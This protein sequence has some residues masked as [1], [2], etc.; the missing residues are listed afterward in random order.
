[1]ARALLA[2]SSAAAALWNYAMFFHGEDSVA[3]NLSPFIDAAPARGAE[4]LPRHPAGRRG[5]P[6]RLLRAL[7]ARGRRRRAATLRSSPG[8]R[9][10]RS[11]RGAFA[12]S[13]GASTGW[14]SEL[15]RDRSRPKL[16]QADHALPHRRRGDAGPARPALHRGLPRGPRRAAR[17]PRRACATSRS[18][19]SATSASGSSCSPTWC[20]EDPECK[21]AVAELL[22]EVVPLLARACSCPPGWDR[23]LHRRSSASRSRTSSSTARVSF[24][25]KLRAAGLPVEELPGLAYPLRPPA[26]RARRARRCACSRPAWSARR[27]AR[28][29][30]TPRRSPMLFDSVRRAVDPRARAARGRPRSSGTSPTPSP[31]TCGVDNGSTQR[32]AGP[33]WR[34]PTSRCAAASRTGSTWPPAARTRAGR[35]PPGGC[36]P[37][38]A[39][40]RS[41]RRATSSRAD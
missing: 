35:W 28:P 23:A 41:G 21:D 7:H 31:G 30:A 34:R 1:M 29:P 5:A 39:C 38:E 25:S 6:R 24:E 18:T 3:D 13:S 14:P 19:S 20:A 15:R 16:A 27:R 37:G 10:A 22:R 40:A 36:A 8:R 26:A 12:R 11:S 17:L 9:R 4:V 32:R 33:R 2:T